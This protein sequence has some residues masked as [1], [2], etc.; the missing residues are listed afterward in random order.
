MLA[1]TP[2]PEEGAGCRF[3][4]AQYLPHLEAAGIDVTVSPFFTTEF[5]RLVYRRGSALRKTR[6]FV[7]RAADRIRTMWTRASWDAVFI[8]REAF[9]VGP[10]L[11]ESVLSRTPGVA[12]IYDFDDA[13]YLSN[14]SEANRAVS[15]LKWPRKVRGIIEHSHVVIAGNEYL[16]EYARQYNRAVLVIP[17][18]VD[19]ARFVPRANAPGA[20]VPVGVPVGV[21]IVGWIGSPTTAL[22]LL[23]AAPILQEAARMYEFVLRV[24]GAGADVSI[25]G[26]TV[27]NVPWS[28]D[29]E[30]ALFNTCDIG[31]YP[32]PDD[33]WA[34]GK[35]GFKAI[36]F[37]ACGVPVVAAAVGVNREIIEDGV[38][39]FIATTPSEWVDKLG[40][41]I[42]DPALRW[43]LG[44][45][46]RQTI[47]ARYSLQANAPKLVAA[48]TTAVERARRLDAAAPAGDTRH[49]A[50]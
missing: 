44:S 7:E 29:A 22:Y 27:N 37:M 46:G 31:I 17:T 9:P 13:V 8:Y 48:V 6:L 47:E 24:C 41:L 33:E 35:C 25:P 49:A 26:V 36:Q 39:G 1:L 4:I 20:G 32:L 16:A 2:V 18:C 28:R 10:A 12:V 30:V 43:R 38:S 34:R 23:A 19:T 42:A 5:F 11:I 3:R 14:T 21:P 40:R 50:L 15:A 45:A